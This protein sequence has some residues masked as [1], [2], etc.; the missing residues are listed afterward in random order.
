M[1]LDVRTAPEREKGKVE[2]SVHINV[3]ELRAHLDKLD[4]SKEYWIHCA[5]GVRAYVAER[6]LKQAGFK[7]RNITGGYKTIEAMGFKPQ[8]KE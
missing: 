7:C 5:V 6:I 8:I 2:G 1:I 3:N 4:R